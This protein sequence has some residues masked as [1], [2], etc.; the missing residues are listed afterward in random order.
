MQ[1]NPL[2]QKMHVKT[3]AGTE[4]IIL[5][6]SSPRHSSKNIFIQ[7]RNNLRTDVVFYGG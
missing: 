6:I 3:M 1:I 4:N 7:H 5:F 2:S